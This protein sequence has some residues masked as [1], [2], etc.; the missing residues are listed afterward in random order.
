LMSRVEHFEDKYELDWDDPSAVLGSGAFS[1]VYRCRSKV[2][3]QLYAAKVIK[4]HNLRPT[5]KAKIEREAQIC[6]MVHSDHIVKFHSFY[7]ESGVYYLVFELVTGGELFDEIVTRTYYNEKDASECIRQILE[8]LKECHRNGIIHRDVKPEN[9]IL[10]SRTPNA[11]VKLTDF[12][13]AVMAEPTPTF[14]G[15]AGTPGYLAPEVCFRDPYDKPVD[16]WATGVILYILLAGY[17]P[18]WHDDTQQLYEQIKAAQYDFPSPEWDT[19]TAEAKDL[20][21]RML[22]RDSKKRITVDEALAHPWIAKREEVASGLHRQVTIDLIKRFNARR[23]LKAG[24]KAVMSTA[25]IRASLMMKKKLL[26]LGEQ[27]E[28]HTVEPETS[29]TPTPA[30]ALE[31]VVDEASDDP[32]T[33][34][35]LNER[36]LH[37]IAN[38][39]W[40][41]YDALTDDSLTAIEPEAPGVLVEGKAFHKFFFDNAPA[42]KATTTQMLNP[43]CRVIGDVAIVTYS[44]LVQSA[45]GGGL[46][47]SRHEETRVWQQISSGVWRNIHFHR[48]ETKA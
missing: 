12:G 43:K 5:E 15:F 31:P 8:S 4:A 41:T 45:T 30:A 27:E 33:V 18:F 16:V 39:D 46:K 9:L 42:V 34:L 13:L 19:V 3:G 25:R 11:P 40:A 23:K 14:Y 35:A 7:R 32:K 48:S 22:T 24:V 17:P 1:T 10:E 2:D 28:E 6:A 29:V 26:V 20:I 36:L 44:R 37:A 21:N 47:S 38:A